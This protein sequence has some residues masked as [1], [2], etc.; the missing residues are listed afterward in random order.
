MGATFRLMA[1]HHWLCFMDRAMIEL[2]QITKGC[3]FAIREGQTVATAKKVGSGWVVTS[4][5]G[6]L[7]DSVAYAR[8]GKKTPYLHVPT[9]AA[10][11]R[12]LKE[13][14]NT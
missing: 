14:P 1:Y 9:K 6:D 3:I 10:A 5:I 2:R 8:K 7:W 11:M 4:K 13:L 12:T